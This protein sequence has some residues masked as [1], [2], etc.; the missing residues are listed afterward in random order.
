MKTLNG[1][2]VSKI[3]CISDVLH[4]WKKEIYSK[5]PFFFNQFKNCY[6]RIFKKYLFHSRFQNQNLTSQSAQT[7]AYID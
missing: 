6:S 7:I 1:C 2:F 4:F 3:G 5:S